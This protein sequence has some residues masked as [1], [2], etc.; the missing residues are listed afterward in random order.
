MSSIACGGPRNGL[1]AYL[2]IVKLD[3]E[4]PMASVDYSE[5]CIKSKQHL[6][7]AESLIKRK[8]IEEAV[9]AI[10]EA[11]AEL[12]LMRGMLIIQHDK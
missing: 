5:H 8:R 11:I 10:E 2:S 7:N 6:Q 3:Q 9:A 1:Q 4:S 12:R